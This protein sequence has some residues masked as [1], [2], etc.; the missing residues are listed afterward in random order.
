LP[1]KGKRSKRARDPQAKELDAIKRLLILLLL[2]IGTSQGEVAKALQLQQ[3]ELSR[4]LSARQV[5]RVDIIDFTSQAFW[6]KVK[7]LMKK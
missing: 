1:A 2:K 4:M 5:K 3:S 6:A 7:K